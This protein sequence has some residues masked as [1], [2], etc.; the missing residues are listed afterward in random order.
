MHGHN[1]AEFLESISGFLGTYYLLIGVANAVVAFLLWQRKQGQVLFRL[2]G[3][4]AFTTTWLWLLVAV[5]F[6]IVSPIAFSGSP[7]LIRQFLSIPDAGP[8]TTDHLLTPLSQLV[9]EPA[10]ALATEESDWYDTQIRPTT[11]ANRSFS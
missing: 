3:N 7:T 4:L 8:A 1:E 10:G 5:F 11:Q 9:T 2:S 6:V